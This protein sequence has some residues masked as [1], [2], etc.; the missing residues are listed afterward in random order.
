[1]TKEPELSITGEFTLIQV[2]L[3]I[4]SRKHSRKRDEWGFAAIAALE[5]VLGDCG[6]W[7]RMTA[8]IIRMMGAK[9]NERQHL[10]D[11]ANDLLHDIM[12]EVFPE[13]DDGNRFY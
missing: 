4:M 10:Y 5:R 1:M 12:C 3:G 9:Y 6:N 13:C 7:Y 11:D 8:I 2:A